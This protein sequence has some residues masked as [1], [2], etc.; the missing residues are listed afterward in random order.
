MQV[1]LKHILA[2]TGDSPKKSSLIDLKTV[3]E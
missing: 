2:A 1:V 3:N